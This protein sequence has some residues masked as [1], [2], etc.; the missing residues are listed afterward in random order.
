M[1]LR[2]LA[3]VFQKWQNYSTNSKL[4]G[5]HIKNVLIGFFCALILGVAVYYQVSSKMLLPPSQLEKRTAANVLTDVE[6]ANYGNNL[7]GTRFSTLSQINKKNLGSLKAV[8]TFS[9]GHLLH[10]QQKKKLLGPKTAFEATP[11]MVDRKLIFCDP[12]NRVFALDPKT[13]NEIWHYDPDVDGLA[14][15]FVCRGVSTWKDME[16]RSDQVCAREIFVG[17]TDARLIA[18]DAQTGK[19]CAAFGQNGIVNLKDGMGDIQPREYYVTSP[20]A[21]IKN[22]VVTGALIADNIRTDAP[23]GVVRAFDTKTGK[24]VW[25]WDAAPP[26]YQRPANEKGLWAR[27]TPNAWSIFSADEK[28]DMIFIPTGGPALDLFGGV[29]KGLDYFGSSVVALRASTGQY[30]WHFQTVHHDLWDYDVSPQPVLFNLKTPAGNIS[31]VAQ[32]TKL[33]HIFI[34]DQMTGRPIF[35]VE[36]KPVPQ[37]DVVGEYTSPTQP[38]PLKPEPLYKYTEEHLF[39]T[40]TCWEAQKGLRYE[41]IFTPPSIKGSIS[42]PGP[43]GGTDWGGA[44]IDPDKQILILNQTNMPVIT[45][46]IK[47]E[48]SFVE[49]PVTMEAGGISNLTGAPYAATRK[50]LSNLVGVP[51][52]GSPA[53]EIIAIDLKTGD[54]IWR[55]PLG[56][57]YKVLSGAPSAGGSLITSSGLIFIG[58]SWDP[59]FRI[60]D[61]EN[62]EILWTYNLDAPATATPMTYAI[63]GEQ[64]VVVAAGGHGTMKTKEDDKVIAFKVK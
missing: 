9:T 61:I 29:R 62:G 45:Q 57:I 26:G 48:K 30:L 17:T 53:G 18:I 39:K 32:A 38:F 41:G 22:L 52:V 50:M 40:P 10:Q 11:I 58:A 35:S 63:D 16:A 42:Y 49:A 12:L 15:T 2:D 55:K 13:G 27:A 59:H 43:I 31:A 37:T 3:I 64:Y 21:V 51:C 46:L 54:I 44:S 34:L 25:A 7:S 33:G 36:E 5:A 14:N 56:S 8:W 24:L 19:Q 6:W 1:Y 28:N 47:K 23:S 4:P 60:F 20:P